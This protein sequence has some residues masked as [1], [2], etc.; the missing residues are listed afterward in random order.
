MAS[1]L[2]KIMELDKQREQILSA[3]KNEA[4]TSA[5]AAVKALNDLG[6]E[7]QLV[8]KGKP[9]A[10]TKASRKGTRRIKDAPCAYCG[11]K[12]APLHDKRAHRTQPKGKKRPFTAAELA[13]KGYKKV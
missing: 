11:F 1:A 10:S 4:L 6:F 12:T 2:E 7:Y 8:L 5:N 13:Q 9:A 3:A